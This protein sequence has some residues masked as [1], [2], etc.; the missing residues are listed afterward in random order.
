MRRAIK[1]EG[2]GIELEISKLVVID[3]Q[4]RFCYFDQ[5]PDDTW[6]INLSK[7]FFEDFDQLDYVSLFQMGVAKDF[8]AV[9]RGIGRLTTVKKAVKLPHRPDAPGLIHFEENKPDNWTVLFGLQGVEYRLKDITGLK[10]IRE[11]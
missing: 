8:C 4:K 1:V 9:W 5:L 11:G 2:L 6:R 7:S 10:I 3:V